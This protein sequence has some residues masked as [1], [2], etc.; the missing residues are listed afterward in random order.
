MDETKKSVS[1][2]NNDVLDNHD[3]VALAKLIRTGELQSS[4]VIDAAIKRA[5]Q[6]NPRLNAIIT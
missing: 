3:G 6:V 1:A 5:E 2:F 4:D